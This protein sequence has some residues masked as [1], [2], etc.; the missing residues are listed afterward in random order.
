MDRKS[1]G[2]L[3]LAALLMV[4]S[5]PAAAGNVLNHGGPTITSP[6]VVL[7]FWGPS[8]N[9]A[10]SPDYTYARTLEAFRDQFGPSAE[11]A[12]LQEYGVLPANLGSG[13][14][15]WFDTSTPPTNVTDSTV[16]AEVNRYFSGGHGTYN[17]STLYVVVIP[18][19]SYSSSGSSTSCGGP[20]LA[21]CAYYGSYSG[22]A[23][24]VLYI[25]LP[26]ASCSGC[27]VSGFTDVQNAEL[28]LGH[29][30]CA[31]LTSGWYDSS[32][33]GVADKC[34]M[35]YISNG[36]AYQY[37]WSNKARMCVQ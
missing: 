30:I 6:K 34:S 1:L 9:N 10:I 18:S 37:I 15:D 19:S 26:Y 7:I 14:P 12:V 21:Y 4:F 23:G 35:P 32:G 25:I 28:H 22:G 33:F 20:G 5:R 24:T 29:E 11:Y 8:F 36:Y 13:T 17:S 3:A 31:A 27:K 16:H 2:T